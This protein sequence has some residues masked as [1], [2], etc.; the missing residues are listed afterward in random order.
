MIGIHLNQLPLE[1]M[2]LEGDESP[3]F[4]D[5]EAIGAKPAG[6]VHYELEVGLSG[7][8]VFATGRVAAPV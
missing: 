8:G 7:G 4:L 6:P 2:R 1:G 5:L 3:G